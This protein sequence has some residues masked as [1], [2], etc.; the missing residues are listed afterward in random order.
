MIDRNKHKLV[1]LFPKIS[2][3]IIFILGIFHQKLIP[4]TVEITHF[5]FS[6][7]H[8]C[9]LF[10]SCFRFGKTQGQQIWLGLNSELTTYL[11][12]DSEQIFSHYLI[13]SFF[14]YERCGNTYLTYF[15]GFW[16]LFKTIMYV[17][18]C[19]KPEENF[20]NVIFR[21]VVGMSFKCTFFG[22]K[23]W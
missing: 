2:E 10:Q 23:F 18:A 17:S 19:C 21:F 11:S 13:L 12:V 6:F 3:K 5:T 16:W 9:W 7:Y 15:T 22:K 1:K 8:V 20:M 14:T 4:L